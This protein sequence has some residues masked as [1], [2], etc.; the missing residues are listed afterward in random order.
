M[1]ETSASG[2][3]S[4]VQSPCLCDWV[5]KGLDMSSR[6]CVTGHIKDAVPHIGKKIRALCY[7]GRFPPS[8][9]H[10]VIPITGLN[11]LYDCMFSP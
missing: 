7:G 5:M 1:A 8:F 3:W 11:K 9:I 4:L 6:V 10:Q 2:P